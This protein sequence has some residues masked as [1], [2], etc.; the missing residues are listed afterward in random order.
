MQVFAANPTHGTE[1]EPVTELVPSAKADSH[2]PTFDFPGYSPTR[3]RRSSNPAS[4]GPYS[5]HLGYLSLRKSEWFPDFG[6]TLKVSF[7]QNLLPEE[8]RFAVRRKRLPSTTSATS[9]TVHFIPRAHPPHNLACSP[10][11][12]LLDEFAGGYGLGI[13][14]WASLEY[15][16][17][18]PFPS[19]AVAT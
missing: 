4:S 5:F 13:T 17:S 15:A 19:T 2:F 8:G 12:G 3:T 14:L 6:D 11:S 7:R 1:N 9:F 10:C 18:I 16:L